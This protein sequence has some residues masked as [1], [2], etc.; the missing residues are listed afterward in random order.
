VTPAPLAAEYDVDTDHS[1]LDF[2]IQSQLID[3]RGAFY[4]WK[5]TATIPDDGDLNKLTGE[6]TVDVGSIDTRVRKRDNHLR[7]SDFFDVAEYPDATFV[8][9]DSLLAAEDTLMITG[10]LTIKGVT[11]ELQLPMT[12]VYSAPER[13]RLQGSFPI[14]RRQFGLLYD[15]A[16]NPI[17]DVASVSVDLNFMR[18]EP[19][20]EAD[21]PG[22]D[23]PGDL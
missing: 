4:D 20:A 8:V 10:Q 16:T 2:R 18:R 14:N 21:A 22:D 9:T 15:S 12:I 3:A 11:Q 7:S 6:V 17:D 13:L 1:T 19:P 23:S 5:G